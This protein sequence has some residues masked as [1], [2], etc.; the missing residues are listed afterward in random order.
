MKLIYSIISLSLI[1]FLLFMKV[2]VQA[3][4]DDYNTFSEI[5][6]PTGKLLSNFTDEEIKDYLKKSK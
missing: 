2:K 5:M 3:A 1:V 4:T 6:M